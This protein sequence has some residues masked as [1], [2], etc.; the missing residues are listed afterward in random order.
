MIHGNQVGGEL[1]REMVLLLKLLPVDI[2][3]GVLGF[4]QSMGNGALCITGTDC[5]YKGQGLQIPN[6][7]PH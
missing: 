2:R 7:V 6:K 1:A 3:V 4:L 5:K